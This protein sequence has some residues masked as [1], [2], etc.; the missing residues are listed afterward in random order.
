VGD[1]IIFDVKPWNA[2][3]AKTN[4]V[5]KVDATTGTAT[6]DTTG[7]T[8]GTYYISVK[9]DLGSLVGKAVSSPHPTVKYTFGTY[10]S[11]GVYLSS[12]QAVTVKPK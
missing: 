4:V 12:A 7:L 11:A 10:L 1:D 6:Y 5:P 2:S 8:A 9:Y 3:C